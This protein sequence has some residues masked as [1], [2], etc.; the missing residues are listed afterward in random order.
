[1]T[2]TSD[3]VTRPADEAPAVPGQLPRGRHGL[4]RSFVVDNQRRRIFH[5][6]A[7][8]CAEK[9]YGEIR[10]QD[11]IDH[12]GLSRR[13]FYDLF[14]DKEECFLAAYDVIV[15]R[16][17]DHVDAA[18]RHGE[19]PWAQRVAAALG[20]LIERYITDPGQA[21]LVMVEPLAV[22]QRA[23][24]RRDATL[25]RF[26]VFFEAG[27]D[28]LPAAMTGRELLAEAVTGGLYEALFT[29]I[30]TGRIDRLPELLPDL[31]YC[32]LVP[33]LGHA[34]ALAAREAERASRQ[35]RS[36]ADPHAVAGTP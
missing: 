4:P 1:M 9:G 27:A 29:Y 28:E 36:A 25:R 20:A 34:A 35:S 11:I 31:V 30:V 7:A 14:A 17:F 32:A 2:G 23:L 6:L 19:R 5:S 10:V 21:R 18:Y 15:A 16:V 3:P 8:V 13:T 12:A 22:G 24:E 26:S 33:Y